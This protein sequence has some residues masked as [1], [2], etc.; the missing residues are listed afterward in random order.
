MLLILRGVPPEALLGSLLAYR[1]IYYFV[2][3]LFGAILF[4]YKELSAT[5]AHL[6][7]ARERAAM[8]VAPVAPQIAGALT[9]LA[10]TVL[11]VSGAT[12][13]NQLAAGASCTA[14]SRSRCWKSRTWPRASSGSGCVVLAR[15]LFR[16]VRAA[17]SISFSLLALRHRSP[18]SS[19]A[20]ATRKRSCS[21]WC[22]PCWLWGGAPS[23][24]RRRSSTSASAR[25]GSRASRESSSCRSGSA[26]W[27]TA[28]CR[29]PISSGGRSRCTPT[30]RGCCA[31][32]SPSSCLRPPTSC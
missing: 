21:L 28:T 19:K 5:R 2:P 20:F 9:F 11:L 10:G 30:R 12:P 17:Y 14:S 13:A 6:A 3:L 26:F 23:T 8:Y 7:R 24:G 31:P 15:A 32:P 1:A 22:S 16:R 29:T 27:C 4:A 25:R 18:P